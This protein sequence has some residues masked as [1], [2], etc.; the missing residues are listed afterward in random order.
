MGK[1]KSKKIFSKKTRKKLYRMLL[2]SL[3]FSV[4]FSLISLLRFSVLASIQ[5]GVLLFIF[6]FTTMISSDIFDY[7]A[8]GYRFWRTIL[9]KRWL[10]AVVFCI[11]LLFDVFVFY[12]ALW[13]INWWITIFAGLFSGLTRGLCSHGVVHKSLNRGISYLSYKRLYECYVTKAD[14]WEKK[15]QRLEEKKSKK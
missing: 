3:I 9:K 6:S 2:Y 13:H 4:V 1:R 8:I 12:L 10:Y 5:I 14:S 11:W 7:Y 15:L